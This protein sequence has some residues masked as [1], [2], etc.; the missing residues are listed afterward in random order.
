MGLRIRL[1]PNEPMIVNGCVLTNG[2]RRNTVT[3]SSYGQI[4]RAKY[5]LQEEDADTPAK[6]LYFGIQS[7]L[8]GTRR[9]EDAV[10]ELNRLGSAAFIATGEDE[11]IRVLTAM[12]FVHQGEWYKALCELRPLIAEKECDAA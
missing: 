3:V 1:R 5:I 7:L 10:S 6:K 8:I 11:R 2:D 4:L 12:E 9:A